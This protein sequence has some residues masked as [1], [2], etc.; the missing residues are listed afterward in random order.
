[1]REDKE[2]RGAGELVVWGAGIQQESTGLLGQ[3]GQAVTQREREG[4]GR[5]SQGTSPF[6]PFTQGW[7][8]LVRFW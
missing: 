6:Y 4:V 2:K 5:A 7:V 8:C 3:K 1:M